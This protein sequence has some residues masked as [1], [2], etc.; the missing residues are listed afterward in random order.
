MN[1]KT[2]LPIFQK[3]VLFAVQ[4]ILLGRVKYFSYIQAI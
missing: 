3:L 2:P 1:D 4:N